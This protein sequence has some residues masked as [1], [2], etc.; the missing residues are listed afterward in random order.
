MTKVRPA[1]VS[2]RSLARARLISLMNSTAAGMDHP[3]PFSSVES[4]L[5]LCQ[6][7]ISRQPR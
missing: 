7:I 2:T 4:R 5:P 1:R 6:S 3:W